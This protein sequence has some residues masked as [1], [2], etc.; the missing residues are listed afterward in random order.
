MPRPD[1][2]AGAVAAGGVDAELVKDRRFKSGDPIAKLYDVM[3]FIGKLQVWKGLT[4][5]ILGWSFA[6]VFR[7]AQVADPS[8][9]IGRSSAFAPRAF[10]SAHRAFPSVIQQFVDR[11]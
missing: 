8:F 9:L 7:V 6:A 10:A 11:P 1:E 2:W 4:P 5:A 3:Q